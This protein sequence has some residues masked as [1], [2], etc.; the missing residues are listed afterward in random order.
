[1]SSNAAADLLQAL[2]MMSV[3]ELA[4]CWRGGLLDAVWRASVVGMRFGCTCPVSQVK[5]DS[6]ALVDMHVFT[7]TR[8]LLRARCWVTTACW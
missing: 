4:C 5:F 1:V 6:L 2:V 8:V 7:S 3:D